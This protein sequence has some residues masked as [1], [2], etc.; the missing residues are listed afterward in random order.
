MPNH[1]HV[2][3]GDVPRHPENVLPLV[4]ADRLLPVPQ[5][6][7]V[8]LDGNR[9]WAEM[10]DA[11]AVKAYRLG[12]AR[13]R[14]LM[15][16]CD[17]AQI[18]FVTV[19]ALSRDNLRRGA[20]SVQV[21]AQAVAT[22]L[23]AMAETRRWRIRLLGSTADLPAEVAR[24]VREVERGTA[25][26][27]GAVLNVAVAY[28]GRSD[29]AAAASALLTDARTAH[30]DAAEVEQRLARGLST[31]GQPD[32]D[33]LIRT[34]GEQR[35]S[36]FMLWQAAHAELYFTETLWPDFESKHF[37]LALHWYGQRQRR[38]GE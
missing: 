3:A 19:W 16:A 32:I 15:I 28:S 22:E 31:A 18:P 8:I 38:Y 34:A 33:L 2:V 5:H 23:V 24:I 14:E 13:V 6:V 25:D 37:E 27:A 11:P 30:P 1:D 17:D 4:N 26:C 9:R 21:I 20:P 12:A 29:I 35:L 36:D 7:A 10:H